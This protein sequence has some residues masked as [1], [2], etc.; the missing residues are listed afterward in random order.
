MKEIVGHGDIAKALLWDCEETREMKNMVFFASGVSNSAETRESEYQR[1]K[2][3]L[4][5]QPRDKR[6]VYFGSLSIF[7]TPQ[8]EW[9]RYTR[10]KKEME[11]LVMKEFPSYCIVRLG[12]IAWGHNP[13][14][15]INA[16]KNKYEA[17]EPVEIRN[18]ERYIADKDEFA[19][20]ISRIP[21]GFNCEINIPGRRMKVREI[22][23][24]YV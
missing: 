8:E 7:Y 20:W 19:H 1:E 3:L 6:L 23:E 2:D 11:E 12:N 24:E 21:E 15:L 22:F 5:E 18:V 4:L 14:T 17:G 16:L 10:H 9:N 13:N